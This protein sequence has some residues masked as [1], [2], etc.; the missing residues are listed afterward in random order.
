[1]QQLK[2]QGKTVFLNSHLLQEVELVC[3]RVAILD[4][5]RL[6]LEGRVDE[7]TRDED[8]VT[9][10]LGNLPAGELAELRAWLGARGRMIESME[11]PRARLE[12]VF[13]Q[14]VGRRRT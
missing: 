8:R 7:L 1:M 10:V 5:G 4:H 11:R 13:L 2:A 6:M 9:L 12:Q 14:R 3:D